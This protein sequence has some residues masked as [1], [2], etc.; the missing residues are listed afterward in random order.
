MTINFDN[1]DETHVKPT[2]ADELLLPDLHDRITEAYFGKMGEKFARSAQERIHWVCS[3]VQGSRVLDVGCS[4]GIAA[5]LLAREGKTVVGIDV[6]KRSVEAAREYLAQEMLPIQERVNFFQGDFLT[7]DLG[8]DGYETIIMGEVLEHLTRPEAFVEAAAELINNNGRLIVTV[9]FGINDFADHKQTFYLSKPW[10]LIA[11]HFHIDEIKLFG[12]WIGFVATLRSDNTIIVDTSSLEGGLA[13]VEASF[14]KIERDLMT[15]AS[16]HK[17]EMVQ[18]KSKFHATLKQESL[19]QKSLAESETAR[20]ENE[21][22]LEVLKEQFEKTNI[23]LAVLHANMKTSET[24]FGAEKMRLSQEN[25]RLETQGQYQITRISSLE[26][27]LRDDKLALDLLRER[28]SESQTIAGEKDRETVRLIAE[29]AASNHLVDCY[30]S[31][32]KSHAETIETERSARNELEKRHLL[33]EHKVEQTVARFANTESRLEDAEAKLRDRTQE[34][35]SLHSRLEQLRAERDDRHEETFL[36]IEELDAAK[37]RERKLE[38]ERDNLNIHIENIAMEANTTEDLAL[39]W[40]EELQSKTAEL[41][42][43]KEAM[44]V[45]DLKTGELLEA[46]QKNTERVGEIERHNFAVEEEKIILSQKIYSVEAVSTGWQNTADELQFKLNEARLKNNKLDKSEAELLA[47]IELQNKV[48]LEAKAANKVALYELDK[49]RKS[50]VIIREKNQKQ[51]DKSM[52]EILT[53]QQQVKEIDLKKDEIE[54]R[55]R[56][57]YKQKKSADDRTA[58]QQETLSFRL[59][60]ALIFGFKSWRGFLDLPRNLQVLA[61]DAKHLKKRQIAPNFSDHQFTNEVQVTSDPQKTENAVGKKRLVSTLLDKATLFLPSERMEPLQS[62]TQYNVVDAAK[63]KLLTRSEPAQFK[64]PCADAS[65]LEILP[66][67][68]FETAASSFAKR[69]VCNFRFF[70]AGGGELDYFSSALSKSKK[71][72]NY[73]YVNLESSIVITVPDSCISVVAE[74]YHWKGTDDIHLTIPLKFALLDVKQ[75]EHALERQFTQKKVEANRFTRKLV[76]SGK[77]S[78]FL[79]NTDRVVYVMHN[80]LP[81]SSGGYATRGHGLITGLRDAGLDVHCLTRPGYPS[82]VIVSK[83]E[84][85]V[86][87][88]R[89]ACDIVDGIP[90]HRIPSP[91]RRDL[92]EADYI[93]A[94]AKEVEKVLRELRPACVLAASNYI[95]AIPACLAARALG[96]PFVY[97]VRGFWEITRMSREPSFSNSINYKMQEYFESQ[98]ARNADAVLTLTAPMKEELIKR[99]VSENDITLA[100]N[101]CNPEQFT[102]RERDQDLAR[103]YDIPSDVVVIGYIGTFVQYEGLE[104][105]AMACAHLKSQGVKFR[106]LLVGNEN[107]SG[108]DRGP[109]TEEIIKIAQDTGLEE[110]LIMP[111]RIPHDEV[112]AYYSLVDI[113]P[114][115]RKPQPVTEMVS[116]IKPLEALAMEKAVVVSS[117]RALTEMI[118]DGETGLVFEKGSVASLADTLLQ[119]LGDEDLRARLGCAGRKWVLRERSWNKTAGIAAEVLRGTIAEQNKGIVTL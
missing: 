71:F 102:P 104:H 79:E 30:L 20:K 75:Q 46:I 45:S 36:L 44:I 4:Q 10:W 9:P 67:F 106:L 89:P 43:V 18:L 2:N 24:E 27:S 73:I 61:K 64:I 90:Y 13:E 14:Q 49:T 95:T 40:L 54:S 7:A 114:F 35:V 96:I 63:S 50:N 33:A 8:R 26:A 97:E 51:I 23:A 88:L 29:L 72:G 15:R 55:A 39:Q 48:I 103:R 47:K 98:T 70:K 105:L 111:G 80:S 42:K 87:K 31:E 34:I 3:K 78:E 94:A 59:G 84:E 101:S 28:F 32:A 116:P 99:G 58:R 17:Q 38:D 60:H 119:L 92:L 22:S 57:L 86:R 66:N 118:K 68:Q 53:L 52:E 62:A 5:I 100:P 115:P 108:T 6:A 113:A 65:S 12:K 91:S 82:D 117:V 37:A 19:N 112:A 74:F 25:I 93:R 69:V 110:W 76:N 83:D 77:V 21:Q 81:Y 41:Q 11:K 16:V 85:D 109:I 56:L 107:A 1:L